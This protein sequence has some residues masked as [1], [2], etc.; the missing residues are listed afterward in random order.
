MPK[1]VIKSRQVSIDNKKIPLISGEM[2]YWRLNPSTWETCLLEMKKM[3]LG[4]VAT[5]VP[6]FYHE[7]KKGQFDFTGKTEPCRNLKAFLEL[8]KKMGF[9]VI[10]R[11]GPYIY[12]ECPNEGAPEYAY[13]YHRLHPTFLKYASRYLEAVCK[14]IAPFQATKKN[15]HIILLQSDNE[16]DPW[17]DLHGDQYGLGEKAGMFQD[18]IKEKYEGD[19]ESLNSAWG[20]S[21][22]SF[23]ETGP[24]IEQSIKNN[25]GLRRK[26]DYYKFK[27]YYCRKVARWGIEEF[28]RNG[29]DVPVYLNLYPFHHVH[30]WVEMQDEC[31]LTGIDL[32]PENE[33]FVDNDDH[34]KFMDKIRF[35]RTHAAVPYIAEFASG[36]WH[37]H[38]YAVGVLSPNHYRLLCLSALAAGVCGWNWYMLVNRDNWYMAPINEWGRPRHELTSVFTDMVRTF[39][40][41]KPYACTKLT[42][43]AVT[44]NPIQYAVKTM[45]KSGTVLHSL[46]DADI[47]YEFEDVRNI[48]GKRKILFYCGNQWLDEASQS[49]LAEFVNAGGTLICLGD[50]PRQDEFFGDLNLLEFQDPNR[51]LFEFKKEVE[52]VL[53]DKTAAKVVT[54]IDSFNEV[55]GQKIFAKTFEGKEYCVGYER[56]FGKGRVIHIGI[57]P[58]PDMIFTLLSYLK[59]GLYAHA[60][61]KDVQTSLLKRGKKYYLIAV[62][63]GDEAK[64][65]TVVLDNEVFSG[66]KISVRNIDKKDKYVKPA[67]KSPSLGIEL[68]RKSG[69]VYELEV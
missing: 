28:R 36:V 29:I 50:Y 16:I 24:S 4:I 25:A 60:R 59:V 61:T 21:Y 42:D 40:H 12:S 69:K 15:G 43:I 3:G 22:T 54:R 19:I 38:H 9:L 11:P 68:P 23:K 63:N 37:N 49:N 6:W 35:T 18:Y 66:K 55:P 44:F 1:V 48:S 30:D 7:Y 51:T 39:N 58:N 10:I 31:D 45:P 5:Y 27:F 2:H 34:R 47:D 26:V 20:S 62:N 17:P 65:A 57:E 64:S 46:Y 67:E 8:T 13:K 41:I 32:Y 33:F 52:I 53:P 14:I 56:L